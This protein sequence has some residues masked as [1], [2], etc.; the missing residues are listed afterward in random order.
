MKTLVIKNHSV[1]PLAQWLQQ[2]LLHGKESRV[3]SRFVKQI[4]G[5]KSEEINANRLELCEKHAEKDENGLPI[6][7]NED[8][9]VSGMTVNGKAKGHHYKIEGEGLDMFNKELQEVMN[10][11]YIIDVSPASREMIYGVRDV[12]LN[13]T[14][15][16]GGMDAVEYDYWCSCFENIGEQEEPK[17]EPVEDNK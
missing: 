3:R 1:V 14:A 7:L 10:E 4:L 16:F 13:S 8:G 17:E 11:E 2:Q 12:V 5:P 15:E 9:T 6:M